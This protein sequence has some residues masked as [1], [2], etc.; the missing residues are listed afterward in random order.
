MEQQL[1][2]PLPLSSLNKTLNAAK[3]HW[4][5]Y[6]RQKKA[7]TKAVAVL[8][9]AAKLKPVGWPVWITFVWYP[10]DRR[11][12]LD[13]LAAAQKDILDGLQVARVLPTDGQR[14]VRALTHVLRDPDP[15]DPRLLLFISPWGKL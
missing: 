7:A 1:T 9:L 12:D 6:S 13:N 5:V 2:I 10:K 4:S 8:A 15:D 3:T 14:W 11:Q